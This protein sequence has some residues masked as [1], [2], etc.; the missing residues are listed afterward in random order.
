ML[1]FGR[2]LG[3]K[4]HDETGGYKGHGDNNKDGDHKICAL[5]PRR[6]EEKNMD[7]SY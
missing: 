4:K 7:E 5:T 2:S 3:N 1:G 6:E